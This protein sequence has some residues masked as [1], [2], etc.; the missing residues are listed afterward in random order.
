M[1]ILYLRYNI[2]NI[3]KIFKIEYN[4]SICILFV[5]Y[6]F[7]ILVCSCCFIILWIICKKWI[8][9]YLKK[10]YWKMRVWFKNKNFCLENIWYY[11]VKLFFVLWYF[12]IIN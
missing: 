10:I 1:F 6:I 4:F 9:L 12:L 5:F 11:F 7:G 2:G 3:I 8:I